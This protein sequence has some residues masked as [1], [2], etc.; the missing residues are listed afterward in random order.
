MKIIDVAEFY[1]EQGGGVRSYINQKLEYCGKNGIDLT[2]VA[3]SNENRLEKRLGGTVC[4]VK[5]WQIPVDHRYYFFTKPQPVLELLDQE[6]PDVIEGSSPW[7]GGHLVGQYQTQAVKSF[8]VHSDPV[9]SYPETFLTPLVGERSV[10]W[11]SKGIW[12]YLGRMTAKYDTMVVAG[13]R[14]AS[15]YIR[16]GVGAPKVIPL[17]LAKDRF[18]PSHRDLS[19]R[20]EMLANC[21]LQSDDFLLIAVS[22]YHPE[23]RVPAMIRAVNAANDTRKVGLIIV[24]DG[25][26]RKKVQ[27]QASKV[28][29]VHLTGAITDGDLLARMLASADGF[30]HGCSSETFCIV[31]GEALCSGLPLI[32]PDKGGAE[33]M[34][35]AGYSETW[36]GGNLRQGRDAILRLT[37]RERSEMSAAAKKTAETNLFTSA[38]HFDRLFEHYQ[39]LLDSKRQNKAVIS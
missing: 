6:K 34:A 39:D 33:D 24:G 4:W 37:S 20:K 22:R 18:S 15:R 12:N 7:F 26:S 35:G 10:R 16:F 8:F 29:H 31:A 9:A 30:F 28:P 14:L 21:G 17:G 25:M 32:V 3:P 13:E 19:L 11:M 5:A 2:I 38:Q 23:K 36:R 27:K 1:S